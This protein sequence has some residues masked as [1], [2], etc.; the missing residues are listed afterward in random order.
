MQ[1]SRS[2]HVVIYI[3]TNLNTLTNLHIF[4]ASITA[5][6][7]SLLRYA[8]LASLPLQKFAQSLC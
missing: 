1:I 6:H 8:V 4:G 3:F 5:Q 2:H 7:F